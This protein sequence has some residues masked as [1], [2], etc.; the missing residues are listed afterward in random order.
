MKTTLKVGVFALLLAATTGTG[1]AQQDYFS[2][3]PAGRSPQEVG[4]ALAEHFVTSPHQHS[5]GT[6]F[7]GEVATWY[8]ALTFAE[9]TRET[10]LRDRLIKKFDPLLLDGAETALV[11]FLDHV[12]DSI[13]GAVPLEIYMQI[14]HSQSEGRARIE[15]P[16]RVSR[17][18]GLG[19]RRPAMG[20]SCS[21]TAFRTRRAT[22]STICTCSP[23][24]SCRHGAP[25]AT[26]EVSRPWRQRNGCL[27]RQAAA[28]QRPLLSRA[29]RSV[30]LGP[31]RWLGRRRHERRCCAACPPIAS[32]ARANPGRLQA[33][34]GRASENI[35]PQMAC[36]VELIDH[37]EAWE[38]SSSSGMFTWSR[39]SR[40]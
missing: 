37:D 36:G 39:S 21:P 38:E 9:L 34:D 31:R 7:Y 11:P 13:F 32:A 35:R 2:N 25:Q 12:D 10:D 27:P 29:R 20:K 14:D 1:F 8:G 40:A 5:P 24:C 3:W 22:G 33:H 16:R 18:Y 26:R 17:R 19:V 15:R 28:T 30:F 6:I 23:S 4:K